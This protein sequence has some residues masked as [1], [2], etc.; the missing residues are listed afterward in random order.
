MLIDW[1]QLKLRLERMDRRV[2][3]H[4]HKE[5]SDIITTPENSKLPDME[6]EHDLPITDINHT[7]QVDSH[8]GPLAVGQETN[9]VM[10]RRRRDEKLNSVSGIVLNASGPKRRNR[11]LSCTSSLRSTDITPKVNGG[12]LIKRDR[13]QRREKSRRK[14]SSNDGKNSF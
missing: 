4:K 5:H 7:L 10:R 13:H 12:K 14:Q 2:T 1:I 11:S 6:V 9:L 3:L 8:S